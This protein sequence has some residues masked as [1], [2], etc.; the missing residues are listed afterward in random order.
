M[1]S[2]SSQSA[3]NKAPV[4]AVDT[5]SSFSQ[6]LQPARPSL[7]VSSRTRSRRSLVVKELNWTTSESS[8]A[9]GTP[10]L[11]LNLAAEAL[12]GNPEGAEREAE[13]SVEVI[14]P[15][16]I[17]LACEHMYSIMTPARLQ[18]LLES[19]NPGCTLGFPK[20]GER[21]HRFDTLKPGTGYP[22]AVLSAQLFVRKNLHASARD[23][24]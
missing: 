20:P 21:C 1:S 3:T 22:K 2:H 4:V 14:E 23:H 6:D 11:P 12:E 5:G 7:G 17:V 13:A 19:C 18:S 24:K 10:G 8:Q 15:P 9:D 16:T